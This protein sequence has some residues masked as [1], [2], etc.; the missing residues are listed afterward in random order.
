MT[1]AYIASVTGMPESDLVECIERFMQPDPYSRTTDHDGRRLIPI[2]EARP[3]GWK[4]V[5][6]RKYREKARLQSREAKRVE[7][8]ENAERMK[9]RRG[10]PQTPADPPSNTDTLS[11]K[12]DTSS[13]FEHWKEVHNHP[14]AKLDDKRRAIIRRALKSYSVEDLKLAIEGCKK[15]GFHQGKNDSGVVYD[16]IHLILRDGDKIDNFISLATKKPASA[17][18]RLLTDA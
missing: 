13:V 6:H 3:W 5:N 7:T 4:I 16:S 9:G 14:R 8:G 12:E 11:S 17:T 1:P 2:D 15:S 10:P 18:P